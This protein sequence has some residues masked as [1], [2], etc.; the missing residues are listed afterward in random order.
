MATYLVLGNFTDQGIRN[1][2]ETTKRVEAFKQ[3]SEQANVKVKDVYW[4]LGQYDIAAILEADN[5]DTITA[6][7]LNIGAQGN[8]R[9]QTH[10]VFSCE[11]MTK[12]LGKML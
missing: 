7:G 2:K 8:I 12:I 3:M 5:D 1:V 6:L 10:R 9:T 4:C 11:E